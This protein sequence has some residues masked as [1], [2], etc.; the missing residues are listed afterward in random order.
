MFK[1]KGSFFEKLAGVIN[2]D[3]ESSTDIVAEEGAG[4]NSDEWLQEETSEGELTVD[5]SQT[6]TEIIIQAMIA[7]VKP[8]N[9]D[10]SINREMVTIKGH[11]QSE[12]EISEGDYFYKELYWGSFSRTILLPQEIEPEGAEASEKHGL[13]TIR[14]PKVDKNKVQMLKV[15][16]R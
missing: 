1:D 13:L 4:E 7:G 8:E 11:R 9:L 3:E 15:R 12:N 6:P 2:R 5:M 16:S 14:L 10:I